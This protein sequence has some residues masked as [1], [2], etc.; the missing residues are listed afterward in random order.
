MDRIR[1]RRRVPVYLQAE[2]TE[3]GLCSLAMVADFHGYRTDL[4]SL[5]LRFSIS[6]KGATLDSLMRIAK[7]LC[8]DSRPLRLEM[9]DLPQ[10][11]LP[12]IVH[13]DM[14]HFVVLT[15]VTG[16][17]VV[18]HD[19]A[20]GMR[21]MALDEFGKHFTGVALELSPASDFKAASHTLRFTVRD[22]MGRVTGLR[23]GLSQ[24]FL[25]ALSLEAIAI[26]LPFFLQW[27]V[28]HALV[29]ADRD[30]LATLALGFGLLVIIQSAIGAVRDWFVVAMS[31]RLNFQWFGNVFAHLVKLPLD[32]FEKRHAGSILAHF[33]SIT[34]IQ[35]TLT[36]GFIQ[37]VVDGIMVLGTLAM[38]LL[39]SRTLA[40]VAVGAV[41]LYAGLRWTLFL[42]LRSATAEQIVHAAKQTTYFLETAHGIQSVRLFDKGEQRRAGWMNILAD[43]FNAE[44]RVQRIRISYESARTLLFGVERVLVVWLAA[45]AVLDN[46]FSVGM[47][48][49]FIAYKDQ[50][51][52]RMA[53]LIDRI[54]EFRMLRLHGERV[55]DIVM[56]ES[57]ADAGAGDYAEDDKGAP[58]PAG[59]ELRG[60][61]FRYSPTEPY[62]FEDVNLTIA[63]GECVAITGP[64]GSGKT[65]LVKVMLGLLMPSQGEVLLGA[66]PV[67]RLGLTKFRSLIGTVMQEDRLFSGSIVDN[68][69]FFDPN[70]DWAWIRECA[71]LASVSDEIE[72]MPMAY[73]T[74]T[75][76]S[77]IGISGGQ[78]QRILLAR[79]L[80]RRPGILVLD[81]AT[82]ELDVA[83][84][85]CVNDTIKSLGLTRIIV[86]HRPETIAMADRVVTLRDGRL[87]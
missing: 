74:I 36:S 15:K 40:V 84:E 75:G 6:R 33:G 3:C 59:I 26:A 29:G 80:Y 69:S 9:G 28:D 1:L 17:R 31:T 35:R 73:H 49:A 52:T 37:A 79:A 8:L 53:A 65:S 81:E 58:A 25:L 56:T 43:Q 87:G 62:V 86:A 27:V 68:I 2:A 42:G 24:I 19:P 60:V 61:S 64:S 83:N 22:L 67:R 39:Y 51:S 5:R 18:I 45:H 41:A 77:G 70:P 85:R 76:D 20:V 32:Y 48:F 46:V 66:S 47:L 50:F 82:S 72:A 10:L 16:R 12:C 54:V 11:R 55:A 63:K 30:L 13:W 23:R 71:R 4:A 14:D 21:N 34:T 38:M 44:L 78:K 7:F 57:E